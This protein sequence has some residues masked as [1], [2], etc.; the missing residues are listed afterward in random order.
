[1]KVVVWEARIGRVVKRLKGHGGFVYALRQST[2]D[3]VSVC[4]VPWSEFPIVPSYPHICS[5]MVGVP[6]RPL[7]RSLP[8]APLA[9]EGVEEAEGAHRQPRAHPPLNPRR[10]RVKVESGPLRAVHLSRHK[11][12]G[13]AV[14]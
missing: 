3:A 14:E 1:M 4:V 6:H 12:P 2:C 5:A 11:W 9:C 7:L 8:T 13:G 10:G